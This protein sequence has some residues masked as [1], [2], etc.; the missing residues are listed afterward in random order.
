MLR[1]SIHQRPLSF[2]S[3]NN[4]A[5]YED[6]QLHIGHTIRRFLR[7][8][9]MTITHF[10][11]EVGIT[12]GGLN[13]ILA[14]RFIST[15]R[16]EIICKVAGYNFFRVFADEFDK[17]I[18]LKIRTFGEPEQIYPAPKPKPVRSRIV[19]DLEDGE[20]VG[21][22]KESESMK[23]IMAQQQKQW[24]ALVSMIP[25]LA[26]KMAE[27]DSLNPGNMDVDDLDDGLDDVLD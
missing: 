4:Y 21:T 26:K 3:V 10:A 13:H 1:T 7:E 5:V 25:E 16:L 2:T 11:D 15:D 9:K 17:S 14:Q 12:R 23:E 19:L 8:I 6:G 27:D 22:S 18:G 24:N 20:V